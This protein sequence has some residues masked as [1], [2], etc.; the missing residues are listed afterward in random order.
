MSTIVTRAAKGSALTWAEGD[1]NFTNLNTDKVEYTTLAASGGSAL[2][3]FIQSGTGADLRT[4]QA[5]VREVGGISVTDFG[6]VGDGTTDDTAAIN[7]A[8]AACVAAGYPILFFPPGQY[9]TTSDLTFSGNFTIIGIPGKSLIVPSNATTVGVTLE[10]VGTEMYV[11][12]LTIYGL[13]APTKTGLKIGVAGTVSSRIV[14]HSCTSFYYSSA[15]GIGLLVSDVVGLSIYDSLFYGCDTNVKVLASVANLPT[16]VNFTNCVISVAGGVGVD[17]LGGR[18]IVLDRCD[19]ESN[20]EQAIYIHPT[21]ISAT[22]VPVSAIISGCWIEDNW[23]GSGSQATS[24]GIDIDGTGTTREVDVIVKDNTFSPTGLYLQSN[25]ATTLYIGSVFLGPNI[26]N[27]NI[28]IGGSSTVVRITNWDEATQGTI[29][30]AI[31]VFNSATLAANVLVNG[32]MYGTF[33]PTAAS[34]G[35]TLGTNTVTGKYVRT[36]NKVDLWMILTVTDAGTGTGWITLSGLP[37]TSAS[38]STGVGYESTASGTLY[39]A[40][41]TNAATSCIV[42]RYDAATPCVTGSTYSIHLSYQI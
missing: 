5:K 17:I 7:E 1:A 30:N 13:N 18:D 28:R 22:N 33:T 32:E 6:A 9:K 11:F 24:Y 3:G 25:D 35:G 41:I 29:A 27:N 39:M 8:K 14:L 38:A 16:R 15:N 42:R 23:S 21:T 20:G 4:L 36:E 2:V 26:Q 12:G 34:S 31:A 10:S 37:F 19:L 40:Y